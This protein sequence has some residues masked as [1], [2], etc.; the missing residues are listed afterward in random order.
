MPILWSFEKTAASTLHFSVPTGGGAQLAP[1]CC[2]FFE[3]G[4]CLCG[5]LAVFQ[6]SS[7]AKP[8]STTFRIGTSLFFHTLLFLNFHSAHKIMHMRWTTRLSRLVNMLKN[9]SFIVV[10]SSEF[11]LV[12]NVDHHPLVAQQL[13]N[14]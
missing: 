14:K 4:P 2:P 6:H 11:R 1:S 5:F 12:S 10:D 3:L 13:R 8:S 7:Q 9:H